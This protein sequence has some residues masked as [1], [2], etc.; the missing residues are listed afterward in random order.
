MKQMVY[1]VD[2][3]FG[4]RKSLARVMEG[5]A[6]EAQLYESAEEFLDGYKSAGPAVLVLDLQMP[7]MHGVELLRHLRSRDIHIPVI[8]VTGTGTVPIAVETMKLGAV[9]FLEKPVDPRVLVNRVEQSLA[10][11][12]TRQVEVSE[13]EAIQKRFDSFTDRERE[14]LDLII[15]G[16]SN[17]QIATTLQISIKTVAV[18]RAKLMLKTGATNTADLVRMSMIANRAMPARLPT[19]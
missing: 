10:S 15:S 16:Q 12:S 11:E 17:K 4:M 2:D 7:G 19:A 9:E 13:I 5:A 3:D 14:V 6:L 18:H 1:I 8:V